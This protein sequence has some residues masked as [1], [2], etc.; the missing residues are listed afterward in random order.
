MLTIEEA[1]AALGDLAAGKSDEEI[2]RIRDEFATFARAL[3]GVSMGRVKD[4][5]IPAVRRIPR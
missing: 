3:V 4:V 1:R 2:A 5:P